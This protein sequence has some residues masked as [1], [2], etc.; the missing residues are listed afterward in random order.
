MKDKDASTKSWILFYDGSCAFC[1]FMVQF[2]LKADR[3]A[4]IHFASLSSSLAQE[5]FQGLEGQ[6]TVVLSQGT[7]IYIKSSAIFQILRILGGFWRVGLIFQ[8]FPLRLLDTVYDFIA[9]NRHRIQRKDYVCRL[10]KQNQR[11]RFLH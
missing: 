6:D 7:N 10:P 8:V 5:S 1:S 3:N 2:V 9:R 11:R 4:R